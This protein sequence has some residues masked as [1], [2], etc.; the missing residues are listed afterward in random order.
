MRENNPEVYPGV[1]RLNLRVYPGSEV[2]PKG[3]PGMRRV[4][5]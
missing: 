5:P 1:E 3:I 4:T 2:K